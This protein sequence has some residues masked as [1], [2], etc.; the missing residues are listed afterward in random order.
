MK[1]VIEHGQTEGATYYEIRVERVAST[2]LKVQDGR[3][4]TAVSG[5]E[6]GVAARALVDGGWGFATEGG[7]GVCRS[8]RVATRQRS[9]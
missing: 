2:M 3:L 1:G 6:S 9:A 7:T 4:V 5:E 8:S